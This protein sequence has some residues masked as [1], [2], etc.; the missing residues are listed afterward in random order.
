[1]RKA[2]TSVRQPKME[3][4]AAGIEM[5]YELIWPRSCKKRGCAKSTYKW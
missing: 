1:M 2:Y 3:T 4:T 5:K